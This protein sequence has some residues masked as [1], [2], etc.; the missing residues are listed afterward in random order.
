MIGKQ[1]PF[2]ENMAHMTS[3]LWPNLQID[4]P[5]IINKTS[6][7]N[8]E[9]CKKKQEKKC[10]KKWQALRAIGWLLK[11]QYNDNNKQSHSK[12]KTGLSELVYCHN[13]FQHSEFKITN[14]NILRP[15]STSSVINM[16]IYTNVCF[17]SIKTF[18][19]AKQVFLYKFKR[20]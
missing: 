3:R 2:N 19:I 6:N 5:K 20:Y 9:Q 8:C 7:S 15:Q 11:G 12:E 4:W 14:I 1:T 16:N 13:F 17:K 10:V 18:K